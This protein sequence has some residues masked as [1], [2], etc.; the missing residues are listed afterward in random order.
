MD[1]A[2]L[3]ALQVSEEGDLANWTRSHDIRQG[4]ISVGGAMDLAVGAKKV[5]VA[6]EHVTKGGEPKIVKKCSYPLTGKRCVNLIVTD[7]A[8]IEVTREGLLL[9][10]IMPRWT[11]EEVQAITE[12]K[13]KISEGLKEIEIS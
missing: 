1:V 7:L 5:I 11:V 10:E 3:G 13:L 4:G 6:M 2:I 9:K 8:V 12:S